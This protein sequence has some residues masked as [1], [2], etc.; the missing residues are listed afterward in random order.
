MFDIEGHCYSSW[1]TKDSCIGN[2]VPS[3]VLLEDG[4]GLW[5]R[6][7]SVRCLDDLGHEFGK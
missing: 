7:P 4:V 6:K 3:M 5:D 2:L 1:P